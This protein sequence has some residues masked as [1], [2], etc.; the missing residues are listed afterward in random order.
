MSR[1][2]FFRRFVLFLKKASILYKLISIHCTGPKEYNIYFLLFCSSSCQW[3]EYIL[4]D[5]PSSLVSSS[6][7]KT[8][9]SPQDSEQTSGT[10][11]HLSQKDMVGRYAEVKIKGIR[12]GKEYWKGLKEREWKDFETKQCLGLSFSAGI[13]WIYLLLQVSHFP[14]VGF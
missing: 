7:K 4:S 5:L 1:I 9:T 8:F 2:S 6:L 10:V 11:T 13:C 12:K 14:L 3:I